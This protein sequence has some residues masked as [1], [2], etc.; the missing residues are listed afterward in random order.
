MM[1]ASESKE[2]IPLP[3]M[4]DAIA[5]QLYLKSD[6]QYDHIRSDIDSIDDCANEVDVNGNDAVPSAAADELGGCASE[7]QNGNSG[8]VDGINSLIRNST[9]YINNQIRPM[10]GYK[11]VGQSLGVSEGVKRDVKIETAA[12]D[13]P[14][15]AQLDELWETLRLRIDYALGDDNDPAVIKTLLNIGQV[16]F[17]KKDY[18]RAKMIYLEAFQKLELCPKKSDEEKE[19]IIHKMAK[20][21]YDMANEF[22]KNGNTMNGSRAMSQVMDIYSLAGLANGSECNHYRLAAEILKELGIEYM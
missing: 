21:I 12:A 9:E 4:A 22:I 16:L 8:L 19:A 20:G 10:E 2:D 18:A 17:E 1:K 3:N 14:L 15:D 5:N 11:A 13:D 7:I 6:V